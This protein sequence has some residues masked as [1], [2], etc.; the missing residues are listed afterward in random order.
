MEN[1]WEKLWESIGVVVSAM[2]VPVRGF[3]LGFGIRMLHDIF[4]EPENDNQNANADPSSVLKDLVNSYFRKVHTSFVVGISLTVVLQGSFLLFFPTREEWFDATIESSR[5]QDVLLRSF[6]LG[7]WARVLKFLLV[8][9]NT[10]NYDGDSDD[11][12]VDFRS[13]PDD[14][15]YRILEYLLHLL[16]ASTLSGISVVAMAHG[17]TLLVPE[18]LRDHWL[19]L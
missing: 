14:D 4:F 3:A 11:E 8:S 15:L 16:L 18:E 13:M 17:S 5:P 12:S 6:S 10:G 19:G 1:F 7:F 2:E 9:P